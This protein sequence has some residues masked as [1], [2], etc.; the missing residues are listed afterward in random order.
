MC[1]LCWENI[2]PSASVPKSCSRQNRVNWN[3]TAS[4]R[5]LWLTRRK[6]SPLNTGVEMKLPT[7]IQL[8]YTVQ[9]HWPYCIGSVSYA[10]ITTQHT[11]CSQVLNKLVFIEYREPEKSHQ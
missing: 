4:D 8:F 2:P 7:A 11:K 9:I 6:R 5:G 10:Y 1:I 3:K